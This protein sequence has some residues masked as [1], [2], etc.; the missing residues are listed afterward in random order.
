MRI[1]LIDV[2]GHATKKKWGATI[3]PN[4]ALGKIARY[5]KEN[6]DVVE[7]AKP[8]REIV[9]CEIFASVRKPTKN[10]YDRI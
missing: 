10:H 9:Q 7:L 8:K 4:I 2:D 1:G 5:H 6:G 3:Y